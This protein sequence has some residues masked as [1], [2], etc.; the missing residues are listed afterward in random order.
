MW[1]P[2]IAHSILMYHVVSCHTHVSCSVVSCIL[3]LINNFRNTLLQVPVWED[4]CPHTSKMILVSVLIS[5]WV[6]MV[7]AGLVLPRPP[8]SAPRPRDQSCASLKQ[9]I[10]SLQT[11]VFATEDFCHAA[12]PTSG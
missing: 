12:E 4:E 5:A 3:V 11:A 9:L 7:P 8:S 2:C 6:V 1:S 10:T